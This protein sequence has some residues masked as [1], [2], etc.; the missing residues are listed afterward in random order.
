VSYRVI[1]T[2]TADAEAMESFRWYAG[3][4]RTAANRWYSGLK[5]A[6]GRL[7]ESPDRFPISPEDSEVL[8]CEA[9]MLLYGRRRGTYRILYTIREDTVWVLRIRHGARGPIEPESD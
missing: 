4:S 7:I 3:R 6:L 9:R 8:G 1:V 2:P 5:R